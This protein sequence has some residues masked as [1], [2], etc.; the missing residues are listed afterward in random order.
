MITIKKIRTLKSRAQIRKCGNLMHLAS[1]GSEFHK[2]YR[3]SLLEILLDSDLVSESDKSF[4]VKAFASFDEGNL[5]A[6]DDIYYKVLSILGEEAADWDFTT[7]DGTLD[8]S[9]RKV[10]PHR[11]LLDGVRSPYNI[12]AIFRSAES[13]GIEHIYLTENCGDVR[14]PRCERTSCGAINIV[15]YTIIK[16]YSEVEGP[17]FAL[18]TGGRALSAFTFPS[19]GVCIIGSEES[20]VSP[21]ALALTKEK[22]TIVT[23]GSKGSLNVTVAA[24]ILLQAWA[25]ASLNTLI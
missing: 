10:F 16:D 7:L 8:A 21:E 19:E 24:G 14:S 11:L 18:E 20:G 5:T 17:F 6:G 25:S 15:P 12:G 2:E 23:Y 9:K 1:Q 4:F 13:F 22:V 3:H